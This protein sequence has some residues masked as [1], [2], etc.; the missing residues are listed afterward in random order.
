MAD[1]GG[2]MNKILL[3]GSVFLAFACSSAKNQ[4][5]EQPMNVSINVEPPKIAFV[6]K[7][8]KVILST[9]DGAFKL[10]KV[11]ESFEWVQGFLGVKRDEEE[12]LDLKGYRLSGGDGEYMFTDN[13]NKQVLFLKV[14]QIPVGLSLTAK[15]QMDGINEIR[16]R[17]SCD[18][19]M[20]FYGLGGQSHATEFRGQ[21][22]PIRVA[23]Q[24]LGKSEDVK[25]ET[26]SLVGHVYDAY[27]PLPY[28]VVVRDGVAFGVVL[29]TPY[30]SRFLL[31]SEE[32]D[33]FEIQSRCDPKDCRA[34][35]KV[36]LG[37]TP[38][39]VVRSFTALY[40]RQ[41][42]VPRWAF[43]PWLAFVGE[44]LDVLEQAKII[45][46]KDIPATAIWDQ[47]Y[48]NYEH[49]DLPLM[50]EGLHKIGVKV[51]T[52][53]NTFLEKGTKEFDE[54]I[55]KKYVPTKADGSPY[56]FVFVSNIASLVDLTNPEATE[57]L[58]ERLRRAWD[59]GIDGFM[60]DYGEWVAPDMH[61]YDGRTGI[62]YGNLYTVDWARTNYE[63]LQE[64]RP[65]ALYFSRSGYLG[66]NP[67][68]LVVWAGDQLTSFDVLDGLPSIIPYGVNLGLSGISAF[69]HD[70]AGYTGY[71]APPS[72][73][74]LYMR[75]T[76]LG[77]LS[78]VMRTHRG[79]NY[80]ENWNFDKDDETLEHFKKFASFHLRLLPYLESLHKEAMEQGIPAMRHIVLEYPGWDGAKRAR[81]E[82]MLGDA[83]F[84]APVVEEGAVT[85]TI[86]FPPDVFYDFWT[87][88][89]VVGP[90]RTTVPAPL[91]MIPVYLRAGGIVV[92]LDEDVRGVGSAPARK[93]V[94]ESEEK[95]LIVI[96][97]AQKSGF[98]KLA[99]GTEVEV[100]PCPGGFSS[101]PE[102]ASKGEVWD[103]NCVY[104]GDGSVVGAITGDGALSLEGHNGVCSTVTVSK[105][106]AG[107]RVMVELVTGR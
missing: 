31:C 29:E 102:C 98:R 30:R 25:E 17:F 34:T 20:A 83:L 86:D 50:A 69:G 87:K 55:Q 47:D 43:G 32:K 18:E 19:T 73:K 94:E 85:R 4:A 22:V 97:G 24:G 11:T 79:L 93:S 10:A 8:G 104:Q 28:T 101:L 95:R 41:N 1:G 61:F 52:Y 57:W 2:V 81:F 107:R 70:I 91:G 67:Y 58:K 76:E 46:E 36:L 37:P 80:K 56:T 42:P 5:P 64:K 23:E 21:T 106:R 12:V 27:F 65:D 53:F 33:V 75:W 77:A 9:V 99:D 66:S 7:D 39:D 84:V 62:E 49:K 48:H 3:A 40:G 14:E 59:T 13:A 90:V 45:V 35:L 63:V 71:V 16:W 89:K 26:A 72:T 68:L 54:A 100:K 60:A 105:N 103:R 15:V 44:P 92:M 96:V 51:L 88:E 78:P 6:D 38:K 82:Y 74:E